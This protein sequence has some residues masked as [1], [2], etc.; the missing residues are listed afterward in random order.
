MPR[1]TLNRGSGACENG[2]ANGSGVGVFRNAKKW[3]LV[4]HYG[5]ARNGPCRRARAT[6]RTRA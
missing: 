6:D 2:L 4:E 5:Y 1:L 3:D